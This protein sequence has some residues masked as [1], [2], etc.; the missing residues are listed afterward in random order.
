LEYFLKNVLKKPEAKVLVPGCGN[1]L[2]SESIVQQLG[3]KDVLSI[4]FE[5]DVIKAMQEK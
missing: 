3:M 4:D 2:L 5:E 1:S